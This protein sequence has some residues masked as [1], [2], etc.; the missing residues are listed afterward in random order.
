MQSKIF[1]VKVKEQYRSVIRFLILDGKT[2]EEINESK[3]ACGL[4]VTGHLL[5]DIGLTILRGAEQS[6]MRR[7]GYG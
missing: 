1:K 4:T 2:C 3:N 6:S 5:S 7:I